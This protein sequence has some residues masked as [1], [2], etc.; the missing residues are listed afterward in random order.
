MSFLVLKNLFSKKLFS[1]MLGVSAL[2]LV[3]AG[4]AGAAEVFPAFSSLSY[5]GNP[6][7]STVFADAKLTMINI[8]ATWCPPCRAEMP[9]LGALGRSMPEGSQLVGIL[10]DAGESGAMDDAKEILTGAKADFLQILPVPE[11]ESVLDEID[12]IPTTIFVDSEGRIVGEPL[13]GSRSE[14][15]YRAEVE[16]ILRSMP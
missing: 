8:W 16:K 1:R 14:G 3:F 4:T 10:L 2:A 15:D 13:V 5:D 12:A 11:M 6:V 9:D 7:S